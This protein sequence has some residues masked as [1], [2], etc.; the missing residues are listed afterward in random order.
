[1]E[2]Q[3][4]LCI[5]TILEVTPNIWIKGLRGGNFL[6][7]FAKLQTP[8]FLPQNERLINFEYTPFLI[9][10]L[11]KSFTLNRWTMCVLS[12]QSEALIG[13]AEQ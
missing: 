5:G 1:M 7:C 2:W 3:N 11:T 6:R 4:F 8:K 12:F 9:E 10:Q 13:Q